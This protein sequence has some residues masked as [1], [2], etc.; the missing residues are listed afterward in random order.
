[1]PL[2]IVAATEID[3]KAPTRLSTP[4]RATAILGLSAPVAM[5]VAIALAVSW[6]PLVKSKTRAV[7]TTTTIRSNSTPTLHRHGG[8]RCNPAQQC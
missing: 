2:A 8:S 6:K 7:M 4:D 1:M 3:R 5:D